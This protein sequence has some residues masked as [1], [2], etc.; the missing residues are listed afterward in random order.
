M[1]VITNKLLRYV[2]TNTLL[3]MTRL[4]RNRNVQV[5]LTLT[6]IFILTA[7]LAPLIAPYNPLEGDLLEALQSPSL[8]HIFGTDNLGRDVFSRTVWG[9]RVSLTVAFFGILIAAISGVLVGALA[10]YLGRSVDEVTMRVVDVMLSFPDIL[11]A[12]LVAAV[13]GP[14]VGN[15]ILAISLYNFP[16]FV[17]VARGA[18]IAVK[19]MEFVE[20]AKAIGEGGASILF[21]YVLPNTLSPIVVHATLRAGASIL[22]AAGLSF[23][24]LGVQPPTP[25]WG[26]MI[27][28][29]MH[30]LD[31]APH[32]WIFPGIFLMLTVLGFNLLGD[33]LNEVLNPRIRE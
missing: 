6:L 3:L 30:Y 25:E 31:V 27:N 28:D 23:L 29:A 10:G 1:D 26:S 16:Q 8:R 32:L 7:L 21:R 24:G 22:T 9:A 4:R 12:M 19:E 20:A 33:G 13:T 17:R 14:G 15:V 5:G 2:D 18:V 11:L